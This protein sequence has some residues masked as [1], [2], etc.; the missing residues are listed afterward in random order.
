MKS[1]SVGCILYCAGWVQLARV[2]A[3]RDEA[4]ETRRIIGHLKQFE[5]QVAAQLERETGLAARM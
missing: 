1:P 2:H 5:P 3:G 4:D